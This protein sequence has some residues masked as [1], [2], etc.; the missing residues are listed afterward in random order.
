MRWKPASLWQASIRGDDMGIE[1]YKITSEEFDDKDIMG[2]PD[3]PS[4]AGFSAEMLKA[5]F[6]AGAKQV[7]APK[8]NALID[9]LSSTEGAA[10]I[11]AV[12]IAGV[13]GYTVQEILAA[14][15]V[16]LDTKQSIEQSN[17]AVNQKFDKTEAQA[18]VKEIGFAEHSGSFTITKYDGSVQTIDTALEKVALDVRL[19]GQ[20]FV[21]TLADGTEQSVDL[22]AFL[23]QTELKDSTTIALAEEAGIL[24]ARLLLASVTKDHLAADVTAYLEANRAKTEADRASEIAG[25]DFATKTEFEAH[26]TAMTEEL[27]EVKKSVSDGKTLVAAAITAKGVTTA[28]DAAFQTMADN[29]GEIETGVAVPDKTWIFEGHTDRV[30]KL[31]LDDNGNIYSSSEDG[32]VRKL[33]RDGQ[34][35]W[36]FSVGTIAYVAGVDNSENVYCARSGAATAGVSGGLFIDT[37]GAIYKLSPTGEKVWEY[38]VSNSLVNCVCADSS[39]NVYFAYTNASNVVSVRKLNSA[40]TLVWEKAQVF[41]N[42]ILDI[43]V[44]TNGNVYCGGYDKQLKKYNSSG[45]EQWTITMDGYIRTIEFMEQDFIIVGGNGAS[46]YYGD[47]NV[48]LSNLSQWAVDSRFT[49]TPIYGIA[50]DYEGEIYI[51]GPGSA[52]TAFYNNTEI[53]SGN[54]T[55]PSCVKADADKNIYIAAGTQVIKVRQEFLGRFYYAGQEDNYVDV[56]QNIIKAAATITPG[57]TDQVIAAGQYLA[58]A[59]TVK[60]DRNLRPE[61]IRKGVNI[62]GIEGTYGDSIYK[63]RLFYYSNSSWTE[64]ADVSSVFS[65][66]SLDLDEYTL[67]L[68]PAAGVMSNISGD[69]VLDVTQTNDG[70]VS[71]II[72]YVDPVDFTQIPGTPYWG[73]PVT[74]SWTYGNSID[75]YNMTQCYLVLEETDYTYELYGWRNSNW[76]PLENWLNV[77]PIKWVEYDA[78]EEMYWVYFA[79]NAKLST[80]ASA[81]V[82]SILEDNTIISTD[83]ENDGVVDYCLLTPDDDIVYTFNFGANGLIAGAMSESIKFMRI[84]R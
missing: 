37:P 40:G 8:L 28:A 17:L 60:G 1:A 20:Q 78:E 26:V 6:D 55:I 44:D 79:S 43:G 69:T 30:T 61:F 57:T 10:N 64:Y 14:M 9:A 2:L 50:M 24:V 71:R 72:L 34:E 16:L 25:G 4:E 80:G 41:T 73:L 54:G 21:L 15:K 45:T 65:D 32:S 70:T 63:L 3:R 36:N 58:G 49:D 38:I 23:T 74:I 56:E 66:L 62:Y 11:G 82:T 27:T 33:D 7:V 31:A 13:S 46:F 52:V 75:G 12:Q 77:A 39:G 53:F 81:W 68:T 48:N 18:L 19:E 51:P 47:L 29:I 76:M 83:E 42:M 22:S 5:R 35:L 67:Y 59:Q 84:K